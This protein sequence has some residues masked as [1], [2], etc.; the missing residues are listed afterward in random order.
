MP[1]VF[2]KTKEEIGFMAEGGKILG[3]V[4]SCTFEKVEPG[5]STLEIDSLIDKGIEEFGAEPSFKMVS[6]Y[7]FASCVGLNNEVVHSI[8]KKEK[9]VKEGDILKIDAGVYLNGYN[10]DFSWSLKIG[11]KKGKFESNDFLQSGKEAIKNAV[12]RA[13]VGNY[14]GNISGEIQKTIEKGGFKPVMVL[15]G[16]G[17]GKSLHEDPL[18]PCF[19]SGKVENTLKLLNGMTLAIEVIYNQGSPDVVLN[20]DNWT[21][22]TRDGKISGLFEQTVAITEN[23]PLI[24]TPT[25]FR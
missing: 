21:I 5:I 3:D 19:L 10:T 24:L 12:A 22:S 15:T 25:V 20:N 2:L 4:V 11:K 14:V 13:V 8:P 23:G 9:I 6:G 17:I 16:H 1:K 18:I 7:H